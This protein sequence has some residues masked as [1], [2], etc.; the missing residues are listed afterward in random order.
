MTVA[1]GGR[2]LDVKAEQRRHQIGRADAEFSLPCIV[3]IRIS[4]GEV[5]I[6]YP[7]IARHPLL[8]RQHSLQ[9]RRGRRCVRDRRR[10]GSGQ[11]G[12]DRG[13]RRPG[14]CEGTRWRVRRCRRR[15]NRRGTRRR[16][17]KERR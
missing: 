9:W 12:R 2:K 7:R 17:G 5:G 16:I 3:G 11:G 10:I 8:Q 14:G 15:R 1:P 6:E 4:R 13:R